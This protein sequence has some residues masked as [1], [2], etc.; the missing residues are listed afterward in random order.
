MFVPNALKIGSL[1]PGLRAGDEQI[2]SELEIEFH[3]LR[4]IT[5]GKLLHALVCGKIHGGCGAQIE[6]HTVEVVLI[7]TGM[8]LQ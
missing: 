3:K 6:T 5:G 8:C 2:A 4:V 1:T 7:L